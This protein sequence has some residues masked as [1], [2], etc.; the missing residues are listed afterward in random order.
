MNLNGLISSAFLDKHG[1]YAKREED[2][3]TVRLFF[4]GGADSPGP[5]KDLTPAQFSA[6]PEEQQQAIR[7]I[8]TSVKVNL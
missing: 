6:L 1:D 2:L 5:T 4:T 3:Q 8:D 7:D